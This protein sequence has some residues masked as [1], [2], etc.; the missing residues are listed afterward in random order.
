MLKTAYKLSP[1]L[2]AF[3]HAADMELSELSL[4]TSAQL[5]PQRGTAGV[6]MKKIFMTT[7]M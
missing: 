4:R 5:P 7:V 1:A 2:A 3:S 6:E